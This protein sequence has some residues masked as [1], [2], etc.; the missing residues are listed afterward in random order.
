MDEEEFVLNIDLHT[1]TNLSD[2]V[3][4]PEELVKKA[5]KAAIKYL[6]IADHDTTQGLEISIDL[7]EKL[8]IELFPAIEISCKDD[9]HV[10]GYFSE[11]MKN[12]NHPVLNEFLNKLQEQ[13]RI[14]NS[15]ILEKLRKLN[16]DI[17]MED[18]EKHAN[19][20][21]GKPH[22]AMALVE[23]GYAAS[24]EE[25]MDKYLKRGR[26]AYVERESYVEPA[27]VVDRLASI[28]A[29]PMIAHPGFYKNVVDDYERFFANLK[30]R[31]LKGVEAFYTKATLEQSQYFA[32]L[33]EK[34]GLIVTGGSDFHGYPEQRLGKLY[35]PKRS[36]EDLN[37]FIREEEIKAEKQN[38]KNI[39]N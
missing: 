31:G 17:I 32:Q 18:V 39:R 25:A 36:V 28:G 1:H 22:F 2:G 33:A 30:E 16:F 24:I 37:R 23:K 35:V 7:A 4:P 3:L 10:L 15:K 6:G 26:F 34:L 38:Y 12:W 21:V 20:T 19:G 8:D 11:S 29:V 13:R 27:D 14:R 9:I 5:H